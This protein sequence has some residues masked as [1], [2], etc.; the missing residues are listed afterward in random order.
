MQSD[1]F[2]LNPTCTRPDG[3]IDVV[4]K[5]VKRL[6]QYG[7]MNAGIYEC[8]DTFIG[9][10]Y[11]ISDGQYVKVGKTRG[12]VDQRIK[13]LQTGNVRALVLL[14]TINAQ[15]W[16]IRNLEPELHDWLSD[17]KVRNEWFDILW[18]FTDSCNK[19]YPNP[20]KLFGLDPNILRKVRG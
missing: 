10:V 15:Y 19:K 16:I 14:A 17:F 9:H 11:F 4:Y 6:N 8:R 18:M 12:A 3:L 20:L 2:E 1:L 7:K 5:E 13:G